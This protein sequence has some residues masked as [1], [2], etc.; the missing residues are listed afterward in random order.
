MA[1]LKGSVKGG[2]IVVDELVDLP[3]GTEVEL[4]LVVSDDLDDA[5]RAALEA[6]LQRSADQLSRRELLTE[7]DVLDA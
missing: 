2:R 3:D 4:A 7:S 5:E 1:T 6:S